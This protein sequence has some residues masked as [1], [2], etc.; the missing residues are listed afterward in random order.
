MIKVLIALL[1]LAVEAP[2]VYWLAKT[3]KSLYLVLLVS[4]ICGLLL[5]ALAWV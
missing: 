3:Q 5:G 2:L 1:I 4:V